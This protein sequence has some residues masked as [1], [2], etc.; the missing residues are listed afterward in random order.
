MGYEERHGVWTVG[1]E[2]ARNGLAQWNVM[3]EEGES[4]AC[5]MWLHWA[6]VVL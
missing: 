1:M 4:L 6:C 5:W 2:L 3:T